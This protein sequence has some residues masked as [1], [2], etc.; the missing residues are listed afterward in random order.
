MYRSSLLVGNAASTADSRAAGAFVSA[1]RG[2]MEG[3]STS[4]AT[5]WSRTSVEAAQREIRKECLALP[6]LSRG[7]PLEILEQCFQIRVRHGAERAV[8]ARRTPELTCGA[9]GV[10]CGCRGSAARL[11]QV[12]RRVS[13]TSD[14]LGSSKPVIR[15][16]SPTR[17]RRTARSRRLGSTAYRRSRWPR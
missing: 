17:R 9:A 12:Q 14:A 3:D 5:V 6:R 2:A 8:R 10:E 13:T 15:R 1:A 16:L 4:T 7:L 11:R